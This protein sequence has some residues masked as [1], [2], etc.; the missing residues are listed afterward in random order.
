M[1]FIVAITL[2]LCMVIPVFVTSCAPTAGARA[3]SEAGKVDVVVDGMYSEYGDRVG[4]RIYDPE[5]GTVCY[6]LYGN[7]LASTCVEHK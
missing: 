3:S 7:A 4:T 6:I 5:F 1:T 2:V